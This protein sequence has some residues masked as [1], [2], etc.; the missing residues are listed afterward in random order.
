MRVLTSLAPR[1]TPA[2]CCLEV[3]KAGGRGDECWCRSGDE[4]M[5][6]PY[7]CI[8][9][10]LYTVCINCDISTCSTFNHLW[11]QVGDNIDNYR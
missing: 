4:A 8:L 2:F 5:C 6:L 7:M 11:K 9:S 10:E 3:T 1:L